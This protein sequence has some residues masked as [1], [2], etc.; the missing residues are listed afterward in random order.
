MPRR[1][2]NSGR[3]PLPFRMTV[4]HRCTFLTIGTT[5]EP[6]TVEIQ[7]RKPGE[8]LVRV[9]QPSKRNYGQIGRRSSWICLMDL[10]Q[11]TYNSA[12][13]SSEMIGQGSAQGFVPIQES[14][15]VP[16]DSAFPYN[17]CFQ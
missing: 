5:H 14:C 17:S 16:G 6:S 3:L 4:F 8:S 11:A 1:V 7:N 2:L 9:G 13:C 15:S 12:R 10:L